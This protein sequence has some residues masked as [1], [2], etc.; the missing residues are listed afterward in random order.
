[1]PNGPNPGNRET[2]HP[3]TIAVTIQL[4]GK[5]K[6]KSSAVSLDDKYTLD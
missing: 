3:L 5:V 2:P 6:M 4:K 1:M